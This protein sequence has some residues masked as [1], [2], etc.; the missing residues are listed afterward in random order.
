MQADKRQR[1]TEQDGAVDGRLAA[2][3]PQGKTHAD[4]QVERAEQQQER[5]DAVEQARL[6]AGHAP[7][8]ADHKGKGETEQIQLA[9]VLVP[10]DQRQSRVEQR[11]VA[12]QLDMVA[13]AGRGQH[14]RKEAAGETETGQHAGIL[15]QRQKCRKR[16]Q[17]S[18]NHEGGRG[19]Q[20]MKQ[21]QRG[22]GGHV[23]DADAAALQQ[24]AIEALA[25]NEPQAQTEEPGAGGGNPIQAPDQRYADVFAGVAQQKRHA[26]KQQ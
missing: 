19:F 2:V 21:A 10:G 6:I 3:L 4:H 8:H 5:L 25:R 11:V 1:R 17:G 13:F 26:E 22:E 23:Q 20:Q 14:W 24:Q 7:D 16:R 18:Q 9:P 12:E 15:A